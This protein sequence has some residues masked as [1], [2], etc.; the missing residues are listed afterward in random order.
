MINIKSRKFLLISGLAVLSVISVVYL[1]SVTK[2]SSPSPTSNIPIPKIT[3]PVEREVVIKSELKE[4][5]VSIPS[6]V[7]IYR[8]SSD[9]LSPTQIALVA[10][11]LGFNTQPTVLTDANYGDVYFWYSSE[12]SLRIIPTDYLFDYGVNLDPL[13]ANSY[14]SDE[15]LVDAARQFLE[16]NILPADTSVQLSSLTF[17]NPTTEGFETAPKDD[18]SLAD[19]KFL[20]KVNNLTVV[21]D[22]VEIGTINVRIARNLTVISVYADI[23]PSLD[24]QQ[25]VPLKMFVN[26]VDSVSSAKLQ[27]LNEGNVDIFTTPSSNIEKIVVNE[28]SL[29]YY[30]VSSKQSNL[31]QPIFVLKG[32]AYL[33]NGQV[34]SALLHLPAAKE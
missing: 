13:P 28:A 15:S 5:D 14:P 9:P 27:S 17:I 12:M 1:L 22:T 24:K 4:S 23:V 2:K 21:N 31:L 18:S 34:V 26:L 20:E 3:S 19:I 11:R 7:P 8:L 16:K 29:A 6:S 33:K 10:A 32:Q 30:K 25:D